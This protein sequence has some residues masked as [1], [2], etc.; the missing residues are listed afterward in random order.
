MLFE[1]MDLCRICLFKTEQ[2]NNIFSEA[3][4]GQSI[5]EVIQNFASVEMQE[6]DGLPVSVCVSCEEK[7]N[8]FLDFRTLII[9]SDFK[10][11]QTKCLTEEDP[12]LNIPDPLFVPK[13]EPQDTEEGIN[14]T[15]KKCDE[16]VA[17]T[18]HP[19]E[20]AFKCTECGKSFK[21]PSSLSSHIKMY[22]RNSLFPCEYCGKAF[23]LRSMLETHYQDH[24]GVKPFTCE[25]CNKNFATNSSFYRHLRNHRKGLEVSCPTCGKTYAHGD[26]LAKHLKTHSS[27]KPF[28]C[29][30][31]DKKFKTRA[32]LS[33]HKKIHDGIKD[34]LCK[35]CGKSFVQYSVLYRHMRV[36]S[37]EAPYKCEVCEKQF[38]YS[39]HL[40]NHSRKHHKDETNEVNS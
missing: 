14:E 26:S 35:T 31:C 19:N 38:L 7:L 10:L 9:D 4:N 15:E 1:K 25:L 37:G 29:D 5:V 40:L 16:L 24:V 12:F 2:S 32:T 22:H 20:L 8:N 17:H 11:R 30:V 23:K 13:E 39:H 18:V 21:Q 36:H 28:E 34:Y 27:D 3:K 6:G 33:T